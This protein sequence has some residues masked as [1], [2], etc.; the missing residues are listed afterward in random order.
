VRRS[1]AGHRF[2]SASRIDRPL[3]A[4]RAAHSGHVGD[5]VAWLVAGAALLGGLVALAAGT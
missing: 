2:L 1:G 3:T 5:Y 4:I